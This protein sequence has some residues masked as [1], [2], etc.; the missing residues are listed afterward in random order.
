M[1]KPTV[2]AARDV[3]MGDQINQ[4]D[5]SQLEAS[6][7]DVVALLKQLNNTIS[8]GRDVTNSIIVAGD[9]N[10]VI[11]LTSEQVDSFRRLQH[12]ADPQRR[13]ELYLS[14]F[15]LSSHFARW[16]HDYLP[17]AG[18]LI[19][20]SLRLSDRSDQS[21]SGAGITVQ[22]IRE[23]IHQ[24]KKTRVVILGEPGAGKTTTLD[25]FALDL[26]REC[27]R[28]SLRGKIPFR[29]D[30][31]TFTGEEQPSD[32]LKREWEKT[33]LALSFGEAILQGRICFLLDGVNQ[34]PSK[35]R[36]KRI[37]NLAH[38]ANSEN[39]LPA[40]NW[41]IFTCRTADYIPNLQL[42][43]VYVQTLDTARIKK[44][45]D[46]RFGERAPA[47][48]QEFEKRLHAGDDRFESLARNPFMLSQLAE[49]CEE[50]KSLT[51]NRA[52]LM[53]DLATR[54]IEREFRRGRHDESLVADERG[55][56]NALL[57]ALSR[58]AFATQ[59]RGQG[60]GLTRSRAAQVTLGE[61]GQVRLTLNEVEKLARD[62]MVLKESEITDQG[63]TES[64]YAFYHHLLQEYFAGRE[65][66]R[67]FRAGENLS[68][69]W[70]VGWRKWELLSRPLLRG[71]RLPSPPVTD[72]EETVVMA[73]GYA[74]KDA[75]RLIGVVQKH[76]L[77]LAARCL[78]E[79]GIERDELKH[80]SEPM[81]AE[82]L[83]RQRD[84]RFA[85]L[86]ARID[87]GL[88]LGEIGHPDLKPE[89]FEFEGRTVWAILPK[90]QEV[91]AGEFIRG[92]DAKDQRAY[93]VE[94]TTLR[95]I[96]LPA[97]RIGR[98][99]VTNAE[100]KFFIDAD[101][102][103]DERWWSEEGLKWKQG[104]V[105]AHANA[106]ESSM[107]YRQRLK[108]FGI[109]K[110]SAQFNWTPGN[111]RFWREIVEASDDEAR[112]RLAK[113]YERSFDRPGYWEDSNYNHPAKPVV[114]V[115][116]FEASAYCQ[117]LS[118]ITQKE[119]R[120]PSEME[121][122]KAAR[123]VAGREYPWGEK[124][125]SARCNTVESHIYTT[126]PIGL[127]PDGVSPFGLFEASG[128]VWNWMVDWFQMYEGGE[129]ESSKDFGEKYRIV[130]GG[131][132]N[133]NS[134]DARGAYRYGYV[135]VYFD[136]DVGFRL[137]SPA[138]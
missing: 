60:T 17:L 26:A 113:L 73:A 96:S 76:N 114:G 79:A 106:L 132:W 3:I 52:V 97:F 110:A 1:T 89:K 119:F 66:L 98:Y 108:N 24:H 85:H 123:G 58:L 40:G 122:E 31:F 35:G 13:E 29:I 71:E 39:E 109:E 112:Q 55:T 48:W 47:L 80:F 133:V 129:P 41:A 99:S 28:D 105:E 84:T 18:S 127:Y 42:P 56:F 126:T 94:N 61:K 4:V 63:K 111:L 22:D 51:D 86:R 12:N 46:M 38:W 118:A 65:L 83:A 87:A 25:R 90:L 78:V 70:R 34:M 9:N 10:Q 116:W 62:A 120:L 8:V 81:R 115:N 68:K 137:L 6:F 30:L 72:W 23:A 5:L 53:D 27:L 16:E 54:L 77:P 20:P 130:R 103:K 74:G 44:Y 15:I 14:H 36:A 2:T 37:E 49:R 128:T 59:A 50:G 138:L 19:D 88:A 134:G 7:K 67:R 45:F 125:D 21:L 92:S 11:P 102:Y 117:W 107:D 33:G 32:F 136:S 82:L 101:G 69:Y 131:S 93:R 91:P 75:P 43:E 124:F 57:E 100:F 64:G 104:G 121:W 135:P 95:Q